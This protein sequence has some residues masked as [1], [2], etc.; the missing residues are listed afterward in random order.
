M[1]KSLVNQ[2]QHLYSPV[3]WLNI[4]G[5]CQN[6]WS[7]CIYIPDLPPTHFA[8]FSKNWLNKTTTAF[9][10]KLPLGERDGSV[11]GSFGLVFYLVV[12]EMTKV[13]PL[14]HSPMKSQ[15]THTQNPSQHTHNNHEIEST[16]EARKSEQFSHQIIVDFERKS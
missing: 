8:Q 1:N 9:I 13:A 16:N 4:L 15:D 2:T 3:G 5:K 7:I 12:E 11:Q 6:D 10:S 14:S